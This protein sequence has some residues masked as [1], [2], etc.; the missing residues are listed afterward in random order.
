MF[1]EDRWV[2]HRLGCIH[3]A[4]HL[5]DY[6]D[7]DTLISVSYSHKTGF[8]CS[9]IAPVF[10]LISVLFIYGGQLDGSKAEIDSQQHISNA[11][12]CWFKYNL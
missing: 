7:N 12:I 6:T 9:F 8:L 4:I 10:S 3:P 11:F 1:M 2:L 5:L